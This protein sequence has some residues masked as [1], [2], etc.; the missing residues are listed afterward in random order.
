VLEE[1][2]NV[3][4]DLGEPP[5][6]TPSSQIVGTQAVMNVIAGERYKMVPQET[7]DVL[8]GKYGETVK[9]FNKDVQKKCIGDAKVITYRPADD[10][11]P[12]LPGYEKEIS[13]YKEMDEDVLTYALFPQVAVDYFKYRQAQETGVDPAAAD[14]KNKAYPV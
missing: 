4:K 12:M 6:V 1:V 13:Q 3:R 2:P 10:I 7:K 14:T 9:P 11:A 5:L 8:S